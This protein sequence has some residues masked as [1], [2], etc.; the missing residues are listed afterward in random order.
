MKIVIW[1]G[2][3][4]ENWGE[5]SI[6][7]G[8]IGGSETAAIHMSQQLAA[9]G[10][11]VFMY[12]KHDGFEG[13]SPSNVTYTNYEQ[14]M[15]YPE[16]L[17]CD[18]LI[19]SRDKRIHR[20]SP[21]ARL[22]ILWV[23]DIHVGDDWENEVPK[24]DLIFCLSQ[25]AKKTFMG[26]Y[27]LVSAE[28][29]F[30]TRN[31]LDPN[32]FKDLQPRTRPR[33]TYSSSPDRGLDVLIKLWPEIQKI[34]DNEASLHVY[35]GFA[36]WE[37]MA[38]SAPG[39]AKLDYMKSLVTDKESQGI[40]YHG[41]QPQDVIADSHM[42]ST[43]WFYP[44]DFKE[45]YCITALEAQAA[46][47]YVITS[48]LAAL[49]ETVKHGVKIKPHNTDANYQQSALAFI[50]HADAD[51]KAASE[52]GSRARQWALTQTWSSLAELW[53]ALFEKYPPT[54]KRS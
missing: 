5:P 30:V 10:H 46:G 13:L 14:A 1:T 39:K 36:N 48:D 18:V 26:Y 15:K 7:N 32:L 45:T 34:Y 9:L 8:G 31:G 54:R 41:R 22:T 23:H 21:R 40:F 50:H 37:K 38:K 11:E 25:W 12:G 19:S 51:F 17:T 2:E 28:K 52:V 49:S 4:Y 3:A 24:F 33:F 6:K 27:P 42:Q 44:T 29:I 35:Y 16:L 47:C 43:I 53:E 20:L